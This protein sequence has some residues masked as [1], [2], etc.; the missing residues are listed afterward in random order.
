MKP[1][2]SVVMPTYNSEKY[3]CEAVESILNQTFGDFEFLIINEFGSNDRTVEICESYHDARIKIIQNETR[4]GLAD[5]LNKGIRLCKGKYFARMDSD[6]VSLPTRFEK[7]LRYMETHPDI[8]V[9]GSW[10]E[11]FGIRNSKHTPP[12]RHEEIKIGMLFQCDMCHST[13]FIR[14]KEFCGCGLSYNPEYVAEDYELWLRAV[15]AVRFAN[16]QEVLGRYRVSA[17]NRTN[18]VE[19]VIERQRQQLLIKL[20]SELNIEYAGDYT[21]STWE[22]FSYIYGCEQWRPRLLKL[23]ELLL[24]IFERNQMMHIYDGAVLRRYLQKYWLN[25]LDAPDECLGEDKKLPLAYIFD[26]IGGETEK[27]L[28]SDLNICLYG[29]GRIGKAA[30]PHFAGYFGKRLICA[31]DSDNS[32]WGNVYSGI[33]CV[34][35]IEIP[36]DTAIIVTAGYDAMSDVILQLNK[37]GYGFVIPF[38]SLDFDKGNIEDV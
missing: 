20:F 27:K 7:Q 16:I 8:C 22:Y 25:Q 10:Q 37:K 11:H 6:D 29:L 3:V 24:H 2:I 33:A 19:K 26:V 35:P 38:A 30:L 17:G 34:N 1:M 5:S 14:R 31:S 36:K 15:K 23:R 13:V 9:L 12:E 4:L 18:A 28:P 32:K 21:F